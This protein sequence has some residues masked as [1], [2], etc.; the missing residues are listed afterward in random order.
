MEDVPRVSGVVV[1]VLCHCPTGSQWASRASSQSK[2]Q[3][4]DR[5]VAALTD[6]GQGHRSRL[7]H[8]DEQVVIAALHGQLTGAV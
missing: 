4:S 1:R 3:E 7:S 5:A 2:M 6:H 8:Q